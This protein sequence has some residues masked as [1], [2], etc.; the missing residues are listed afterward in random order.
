MMYT[1]SENDKVLECWQELS[2][3]N[4]DGKIEFDGVAYKGDIHPFTG[5]DGKICN[6]RQPGNEESIWN[7]SDKR[8]LFVAKELNDPDNPY[9]SRVVMAYDPDNGIEPTDR[10]L[11]SMLYIT[12]GVME[13]TAGKAVEFNGE[14]SMGNL[15]D[16]WDKAAV[17]K[18]NVKKQP[19]KSVADMAEINSSM[20]EYRDLLRKQLQLLNANIIVCCDN[21]AGILS[22]IKELVYPDAVQLSDEAWYDKL[23]DTLLIESYHLSAWMISYEDKYNR[24]IG[25]YVDAL[26]KIKA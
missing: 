10:F 23:S 16:T 11:K 6:E 26:A 25:N 3:K 17:A 22:T 7:N 1:H 2:V 9:D 24:V 12:N 21:R 19:G 5:D 15:M 18:I 14:E 13:S 20:Q 4:G 8:I